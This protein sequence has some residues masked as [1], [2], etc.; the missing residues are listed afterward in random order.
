M[1][2]MLVS[3]MLTCLFM[4]MLMPAIRAIVLPLALLVT[5]IGAADHEHDAAAPH[6]LAVLAD[7]LD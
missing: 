6:D 3:P 7:F 1:P 5:R 4:G 2:K